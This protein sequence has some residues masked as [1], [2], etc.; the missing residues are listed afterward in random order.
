MVSIAKIHFPKTGRTTWC[1]RDIVNNSGIRDVSERRDDVTCKSCLESFDYAFKHGKP[2]YAVSFIEIER[3]PK[4]ACN[5]CDRRFFPKS[6]FNKNCGCLKGS[7][8]DNGLD[9]YKIT[10]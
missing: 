6:K 3:L 7:I 4:I 10:L 9:E 2:I 1:G 8:V 5:R